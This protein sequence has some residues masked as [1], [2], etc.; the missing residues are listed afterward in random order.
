ME[1]VLGCVCGV[2]EGD[3]GVQGMMQEGVGGRLSGS[4]GWVEGDGA[5]ERDVEGCGCGV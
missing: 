4:G 1:G 3:G 5:V 2:M